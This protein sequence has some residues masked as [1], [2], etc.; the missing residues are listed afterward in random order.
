MTPRALLARVKAQFVTLLHDEDDKLEALLVQALNEYQDKAGVWLVAEI[1]KDQQKEGGINVPPY[2]LAVASAHD[3]DYVWL[4]STI[5]ADKLNVVITELSAPPFTVNYL[6]A[7]SEYDLD[8]AELPKTATGI[9]QKYLKVLIDIPNTERE[10]YA[11]TAAGMPLD[12]LP[13]LNELHD[14]KKQ[15]EDEMEQTAGMLMP[16]MLL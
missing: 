16:S 8:K 15:L 4:E 11:R 14:R 12:G 3:M 9:L 7:L 6:A 1:S 2:F 13:L 5:K 10:Q